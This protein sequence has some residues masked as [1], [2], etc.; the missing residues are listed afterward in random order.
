MSAPVG[1][2]DSNKVF[3]GGLSPNCSDE[4][5]QEYLQS[6]GPV[7]KSEIITDDQGGSRGYAFATFFDRQSMLRSVGTNH[8]LAGKQF[9]IKAHNDVKEEKIGGSGSGAK[10][11]KLFI[12][13]MKIT[14]KEKDIAKYFS[15]FGDVEEVLII[16]DKFTKVSKGYG[17]VLFKCHSSVQR[18]MRGLDTQFV[19]IKSSRIS[20]K[21]VATSGKL[22]A[23]EHY[24]NINDPMQYD[25]YRNT[26]P[27]TKPNKVT[28]EKNGQNVGYK[29]ESP[30]QDNQGFQRQFQHD[31]YSTDTEPIYYEYNDIDRYESLYDINHTQAIGNR[32]EESCFNDPDGSYNCNYQNLDNAY[33]THDPSNLYKDKKYVSKVERKERR[34]QQYSKGDA[35]YYEGY[36]KSDMH[37]SEDLASS[38]PSQHHLSPMKISEHSDNSTKFIPNRSA[39]VLAESGYSALELALNGDLGEPA[40]DN[41]IKQR[42]K[43]LRASK[44]SKDNTH[45]D[46]QLP[47]SE[48]YKPPAQPTPVL[49]P[50]SPGIIVHL[51]PESKPLYLYHPSNLP[52]VYYLNHA[53]IYYSTE[54]V[55]GWDQG[56][57]AHSTT[58]PVYFPHT[59][60]YS[61]TPLQQQQQQ[62]NFRLAQTSLQSRTTLSQDHLITPPSAK[63]NSRV[64]QSSTGANYSDCS[65]QPPTIASART[66][67]PNPPRPKPELTSPGTVF[68]RMRE[69]ESTSELDVLSLDKVLKNRI[70]RNL[71]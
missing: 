46:T 32:F 22:S 69:R 2:H 57:D 48:E 24:I 39:K 43:K 56:F 31:I 6:F 7:R 36:K 25:C 29:T 64:E 38:F 19:V 17:F 37:A 33:S 23:D 53:P 50:T 11:R 28:K 61:S 21:E 18:V 4:M 65:L 44:Q 27:S 20:I 13:N 40:K 55:I 30:G 45:L 62:Q 49:V 3:I 52:T 60:P 67:P 63:F 51:H 14:I 8:I 68:D 34:G 70:L 47:S 15:R 5:L 58:Q 35:N 71:K 12:W 10:C 42:K 26:T 1:I 16:R 66:P 54:Q 9:T 41:T 59:Q